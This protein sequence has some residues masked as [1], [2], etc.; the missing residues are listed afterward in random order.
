MARAGGEGL[1]PVFELQAVQRVRVTVAERRARVLELLSQLRLRGRVDRC[2][3]PVEE[4]VQEQ[5]DPLRPVA[6][7]DEVP[8]PKR[9]DLLRAMLEPVGRGGLCREPALT[10]LLPVLVSVAG[11]PRT[12]A[13]DDG[14]TLDAR[15]D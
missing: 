9:D 13:L 8:A 4:R 11:L 14:A 3:V 10:T 12:T 7:G 5:V 15:H 6:G 1:S 2:A